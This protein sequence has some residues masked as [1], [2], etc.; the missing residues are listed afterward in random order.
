MYLVVRVVVMFVWFWCG[1]NLMM[2]VLMSCGSVCRVLKIWCGV[3][4]LGLW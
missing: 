2:L 4:L 3:R 1:L